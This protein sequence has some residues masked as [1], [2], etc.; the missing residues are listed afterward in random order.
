[1][2]QSVAF[3]KQKNYDKCIAS[4]QQWLECDSLSADAHYYIGASYIYK[5]DEVPM[6]GRI[7]SLSYRQSLVKRG[8]LYAK[9]EPALETYRKMMPQAKDEWA[10]LL[11][12]I[13]LALNKGDKFAEI[14]DILAE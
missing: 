6:E 4:A 8:E 14:E 12:K 3:F 11:Y 7:N 5:V 2:A 1:M 13:Y 10:P 9:A